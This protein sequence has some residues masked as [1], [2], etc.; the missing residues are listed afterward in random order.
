MHE[1]VFPLFSLFDLRLPQP[2]ASLYL[3]R[4]GL[5][6]GVSLY[7]LQPQVFVLVLEI[8]LVD[9]C[10]FV[11]QLDVSLFEPLE[12]EPVFFR[13]D[14]QA[15]VQLLELDVAFE[16]GLQ[17]GEGPVL[18]GQLLLLLLELGLEHLDLLALGP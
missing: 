17:P 4:E 6:L 7:K 18:L 11:G 9:F 15:V 1:L 10:E 8:F 5:D 16:L 14:E 12:L 3:R 13:L 2:R